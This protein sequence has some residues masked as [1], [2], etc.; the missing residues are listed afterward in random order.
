MLKTHII[1]QEQFEYDLKSMIQRVD[2]WSEEQ[3]E[4]M[5]IFSILIEPTE[6]G[7][8]VATIKYS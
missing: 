5:I 2:E 4:D 3:D 8:W 1:Q 7:Q 6:T